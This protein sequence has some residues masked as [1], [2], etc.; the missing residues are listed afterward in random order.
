MY[1]F[2]LIHLYL[3]FRFYF[4]HR[5]YSELV[6]SIMALQQ[7]SSASSSSSNGTGA[8]AGAA[9]SMGIGGGGESML[10]HDMSQLKNEMIG[11]YFRMYFIFIP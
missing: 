9:D 4:F 2:I 6:A 11:V 1:Q 8:G 7:S 5:R 3:F 10:Q